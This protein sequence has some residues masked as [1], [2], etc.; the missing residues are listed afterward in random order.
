[1]TTPIPTFHHGLS[2]LLGSVD[3]GFNGA[4]RAPAGGARR[5]NPHLPGEA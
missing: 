5:E 4:W 1:M 2:S 3:A